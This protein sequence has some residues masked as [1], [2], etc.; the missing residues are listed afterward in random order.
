MCTTLKERGEAVLMRSYLPPSDALPYAKTELDLDDDTIRNVTIKDAVRATSAA[1]MYFPELPLKTSKSSVIF[2]DGGVLNNN[3]IDQLWRAR[4]DLVSDTDPAPKI[5]CVLSVGT[6][7]C[8][9]PKAELGFMTGLKA[10]FEPVVP[11]EN[12][13]LAGGRA[14]LGALIVPILDI[15]SRPVSKAVA[16]LTNTDAKHVDFG[17]YI[18]RMKN[19]SGEADK[20]T[21]YFRFNCP[22]GEKEIDMASASEMKSLQGMTETWLKTDAEHI[23]KIEDVAKLLVNTKP[24]K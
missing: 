18:A 8:S 5:A 2:W 9:I 10:W 22:T 17:R 23:K 1:P 24:K 21:Q 6:S 3:P 14:A 7:F 16:F 12:F 13:I 20:G 11:K 4:L 19:R 15:W